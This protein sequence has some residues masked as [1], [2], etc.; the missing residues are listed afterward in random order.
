DLMGDA[1]LFAHLLRVEELL[2]MTLAIIER[3][4]MNLM[5]LAQ[6]AVEQ[7]KGIHPARID[8]NDPRAGMALRR[9][10]R[11][12]GMHGV[13]LVDY[14]IWNKGAILT[15]LQGSS[16]IG[17]PWRGGSG[18]QAIQR[19]QVTEDLGLEL[20]RVDRLGEKAIH[21]GAHRLALHI[22]GGGGGQGDDRQ[23]SVQAAVE[24]ADFPGRGIAV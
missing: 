5:P 24:R 1:Q 6:Q 14:G 20:A 9:S 11:M 10:L 19:L 13:P 16:L 21:A 2:G 18:G 4:R 12:N 7:R 3:Q 22:L 17:G 8:G 15:N 23:P